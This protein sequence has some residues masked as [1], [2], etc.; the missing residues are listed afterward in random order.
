M[1][2]YAHSRDLLKGLNKDSKDTY[3]FHEL[4][5]LHLFTE[6][7]HEDFSSIIRRSTG[8]ITQHPHA[9]WEGRVRVHTLFWNSK[10]SNDAECPY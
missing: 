5:F 10:E 1:V 7:F 3:R 9:I 2:K 6:L 4:I 8:F